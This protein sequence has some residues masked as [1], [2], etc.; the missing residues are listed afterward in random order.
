[1]V[2]L[3]LL[4]ARDTRQLLLVV[5]QVKIAKVM[6]RLL[7]VLMPVLI[8]NKDQVRS[9][10]VDMLVNVTSAVNQLL[11]VSVLVIAARDITQLLSVPRLVNVAKACGEF[12]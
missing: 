7:S 3:L 2:V 9:L 6:G 12:L 5:E 11:S 4:A 10:L 8:V 1:L